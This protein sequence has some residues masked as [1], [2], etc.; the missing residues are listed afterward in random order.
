MEISNYID[1]TD[2]SARFMKND[3]IFKKFLF[4]FPGEKGFSE[5]F[6]LLEK[7]DVDVEEAFRAA[8]TMKGLAA[9]LSLKSISAI[10]VPMT[11]VLRGGEMPPKEQVEELKKA[12]DE[13]L[14][15]IAKIQE[16]NIPLF[17]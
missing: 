9:N 3:G 1:V 6:E 5:L 4:R 13:M 12:Y 16:E 7:E 17:V 10:L 2:A 8:H 11:E 15:V 14:L